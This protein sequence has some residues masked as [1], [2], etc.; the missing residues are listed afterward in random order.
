MARAPTHRRRRLR[1]LPFNRMIPNILTLLALCAGLS[2]IR[3]GL[4]TE[5]E[6]ALLA[7]MAAAILDGL[8]GRIA[9]ILKGTSKFGAELDSLADFVSFGVVPPILLYLWAMQEAGRFG[10]ILVLLYSV[11]MVLRLARFNTLLEDADQPAWAANFFTGV[12]APMGAGLVLM[13]MALWLVTDSELFRNPYLVSIVMIGVAAL[14][15]SRIPTFSFKKVKVP[16]RWVLPTMLTVG[17]YAALLI[18]APW[19]TVAATLLLYLVSIPFGMRAYRR[20]LERSGD[21]GG[22]EEVDEIEEPAEPTEDV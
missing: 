21:D 5:W 10:W 9:R 6:K 1:A 12:P 2:A 17:L 18:N 16:S 22:I 8:D 19:A 15:V 11:C 20:M 3:Y 14:L 7:I 4:T 13:P